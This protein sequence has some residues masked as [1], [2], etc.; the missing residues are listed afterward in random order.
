VNNAFDGDRQKAFSVKDKC[1]RHRFGDCA[2]VV[3]LPLFRKW[4]DYSP[5]TPT[6]VTPHN[7]SHLDDPLLIVQIRAGDEA[8]FGRLYLRYYAPLLNFV[9]R[10]VHEMAI[11]E[12]IVQDVFLAIWAGRAEWSPS[13]GLD[14]YLFG[15]VRNRALNVGRAA[16][17]AQRGVPDL[18]RA[19]TPDQSLADAEILAGERELAVR[20]AVEMLPSRAREAVTLR[21]LHGL[22]HANVASVLGVSEEAARKLVARAANQLR[23]LLKDY[24]D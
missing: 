14:A 10:Y 21:W 8:A 18:V 24:A 4:F 16:G 6:L 13:Y 23:M 7:S 9:L 17:S 22:S 11:A 12:E 1:I 5:S 19:L 3:H 20:A 15:A 2:F